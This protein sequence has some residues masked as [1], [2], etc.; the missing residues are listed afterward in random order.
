VR[1][2]QK[3]RKTDRGRDKERILRVN[4]ICCLHFFM[5]FSLQFVVAQFSWNWWV[6]LLDM[7]TS[8]MNNGI[9]ELSFLQIDMSSAIHENWPPRI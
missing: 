9:P 1:K 4:I 3:E 8:S 6:A 2:R 5:N 7:F